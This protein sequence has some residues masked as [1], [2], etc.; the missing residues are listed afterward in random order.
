[1]TVETREEGSRLS[2]R[3]GGEQPQ[4]GRGDR[5]GVADKSEVIS[6]Y[7]YASADENDIDQPENGWDIDPTPVDH[8]VAEEETSMRSRRGSHGNSRPSLPTFGGRR[9]EALRNKSRTAVPDYSNSDLDWLA[10]GR[11]PFAEPILAQT[12]ATSGADISWPTIPGEAQNE[13]F[14]AERGYPR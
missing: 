13:A 12:S 9:R 8:Y 2:Q 7:R 5:H 3:T 14:G 11:D 6:R 1:M 4:P 10:S